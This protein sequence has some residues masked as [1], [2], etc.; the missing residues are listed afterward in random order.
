MR[1]CSPDDER[2]FLERKARAYVSQISA[3]WEQ[4]VRRFAIRTFLPFLKNTGHALELGCG[5]GFTTE[6]IA[7][8]VGSLDVVEGSEF[9]LAMAKARTRNLSNVRFFHSLFEEFRPTCS[10][11]Y[12]FALWVLEH[13]Q[14]PAEL[15]KAVYSFLNPEGVLFVTVPNANA[16]SRQLARHMGLIG[17]LKDLTE[18]DVRH[19]HRRVYDRVFLN[20]ELARAGFVL[21]SQSGLMLKPFADFQMD[22][23]IGQ[24]VLQEP[25]IEGLWSLGFEYPDLCAYLYAVCKRVPN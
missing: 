6:W 15:L 7:K 18:N 9:F 16:L 3:P 22:E 11:D 13:V 1:E 20:R 17:D 5:E 12:V 21:I 19:G 25:Q 4:T 2:D 24:G 8:I 10:Y 23:L 14:N